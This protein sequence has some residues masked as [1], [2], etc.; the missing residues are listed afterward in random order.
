MHKLLLQISAEGGPQFSALYLA[1]MPS[2]CHQSEFGACVFAT[3]LR[4]LFVSWVHTLI[5]LVSTLC[6]VCFV[7]LRGQR[8]DSAGCG[9]LIPTAVGFRVTAVW[10]PSRI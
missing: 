9:V 5:I 6:T 7:G 2:W 10:H 3:H 4:I 8:A 1:C